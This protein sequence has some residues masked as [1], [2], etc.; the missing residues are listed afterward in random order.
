LAHLRAGLQAG[1]IRSQAP[2]ILREYLDTRIAVLEQKRATPQ[3]TQWMRQSRQLQ[4]A[5]W[6]QA[7]DEATAHPSPILT[8]YTEALGQIVTKEAEQAAAN[9]DRVPADI[10]ILLSV[11]SIMVTALV[12]YGQERRMALVTFVPILMIA[13]ALCLLSDL[14]SPVA[15]FINVGE[16]SLRALSA[17]LADVP[18]P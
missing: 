13:T 2:P 12:G 4:R 7:N 6:Q 16:D 15:G 1:T 9:D 11:L 8:S 5:L 14:S 18:Q 17:E 3:R 10:W